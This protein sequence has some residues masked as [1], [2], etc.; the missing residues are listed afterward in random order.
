MS[1]SSNVELPA[2]DRVTELRQSLAEIRASVKKA[3]P[4]NSSPTLVA[5][6][7]LKPASDIQACFL[8]NQLDFGEN[9]VQELEEK[10]RILPPDIRWHFIGTLQSNKA[11]NLA[12]I[13]NLYSIQTLGSIKA[14]TAL[15][16]ALPNN[17]GSP[18]RVLVQ[19]NTSGEDAKSGL[20][21]LTPSSTLAESEL[22][23]LIKHVVTSCPKLRLEG[24]MTIGS[25]EQSIAASDSQE[26]PDFERLK[27]TCNIVSKYLQTT[28][29]DSTQNWGDETTGRLLLSMGMSSDF[30]AALASGSDI[31]RVGTGIFGQRPAKTG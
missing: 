19:V 22:I 9:Y 3:S 14:A 28:F 4:L 16:K 7:K 23:A 12:A 5:V 13:P 11:K 17:R 31:V 29:S 1:E 21:S 8:D 20:P 15:N 10:A 30:E 26:N 24:L 2:A 6:S 27:E 25:L 18:L